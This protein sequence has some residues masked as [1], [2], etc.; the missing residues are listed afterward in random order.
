[1]TQP[2]GPPDPAGVIQLEIEWTV[3]APR[4]RVWEALVGEVAAWWPADF[5]CLGR[6]EKRHLPAPVSALPQRAHPLAPARRL[7]P[8]GLLD[9]RRQTLRRLRSRPLHPGQLGLQRLCRRH[10]QCRPLHHSL[11]HHRRIQLYAP[12]PPVICPKIRFL[13]ASTPSQSGA[14]RCQPDTRSPRNHTAP[15]SSA[16][17]SSSYVSRRSLPSLAQDSSPPT[18]TTIPAAFSPT[19]RPAPSSATRSSGRSSPPPSR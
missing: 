4:E 14:S 19:P 8:P 5:Y 7:Y 11:R 13:G 10:A 1:M 2:D 16:G 6:P 18:S 12:A 17:A 3:R 9:H 15:E